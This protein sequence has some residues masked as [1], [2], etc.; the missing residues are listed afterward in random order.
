VA[1]GDSDVQNGLFFQDG[2]LVELADGTTAMANLDWP[3]SVDYL[4]QQL[5]PGIVVGKPTITYAT[6]QLVLKS[7]MAITVD[8]KPYKVCH[9]R[10]IDDGKVSVAEL[11][12]A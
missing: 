2:V 3:E 4:G 9:I 1:L 8:G 11:S 10:R 12:K 5:T 6:S 7:D